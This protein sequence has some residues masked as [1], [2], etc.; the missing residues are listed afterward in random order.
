M[1]DKEYDQTF[2]LTGFFNNKSLAV[3]P[4]YLVFDCYDRSFAKPIV[5]SEQENKR[6]PIFKS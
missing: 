1:F 2:D 4:T 6:H 3:P 5:Q